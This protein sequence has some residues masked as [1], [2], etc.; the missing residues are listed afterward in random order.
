MTLSIQTFAALTSALAIVASIVSFPVFGVTALLIIPMIVLGIALS[1]PQKG[2]QLDPSGS[3]TCKFLT[4]TWFFSIAFLIGSIITL[5]LLPSLR[6]RVS[7]IMTTGD[8]R[9][10][11]VPILLQVTESESAKLE[12]KKIWIVS[13]SSGKRIGELRYVNRRETRNWQTRA[14][15]TYTTGWLSTDS[16]KYNGTY[17]ANREFAVSFGEENNILLKPAQQSSTSQSVP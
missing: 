15:Q 17:E 9:A 11:H 14:V 13:D 6:A 8:M 4:K 2:T 1:S 16:S 3:W 10:Y 7:R 12:G 5:A